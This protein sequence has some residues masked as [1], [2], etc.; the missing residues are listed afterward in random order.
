MGFFN[1]RC[2][3]CGKSVSKEASHCSHCG[4]PTANKWATCHQCGTSVG[5]ESKFCWKCGTEQKTDSRENFYGDRWRRSANDFAARVEMRV[6]GEVLHQG[7]LIDEGTVAVM[8]Q[9]GKPQGI[10]EPGYHSSEGFFSKLMGVNKNASAHAILLDME[11]AEVDFML[12]DVRLQ[13]LVPVDSRVRLLFKVSDAE[14]F[15][16]TVMGGDDSFTTQDLSARFQADVKS[17]AEHALK[18]QA[19]DKIVFAVSEREILEAGMQEKL[20]PALEAHGLSLAG[21][22]LAQFG[23][24]AYDQLKEKF[25]ELERLSRE[26]EAAR[27]LRD[28]VRAEKVA[29]YHDEEELK[30][31]Y[32][33][34]QTDYKLKS[35][36]REQEEARFIQAAEQQTEVEGV[37]LAYETRRAEILNRLDEQKLRH[38]S[39]L[40]D[41]QAELEQ[42][43]ARFEEDMRQQKERFKTGQEQ[44]K[45]QAKTDLEVAKQGIEAMKAVKAAKLEAKAAENEIEIEAEAKRLELRGNAS[46]QSLL[47]TLSGEQAD[48]VLKLAELEMRKGLSPEQALAMI[49]EKSPEIAPAV[50]DAIQARE[51]GAAKVEEPAADDDDEDVMEEER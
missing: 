31:A 5:A 37:R 26:A 4:C 15:V 44:Q 29:A 8:F 18:D 47:A 7:L 34:V 23:G 25:S 11:A 3:N 43:R 10:L 19:L 32:A 46:L 16:T 24:P 40:A 33:K 2:P 48:R 20:G 45:E 14:K 21:V 49:A 1:N 13:G 39:E 12:E 50:A 42:N 22:R 36:D 17:A 9:D 6:P 28:A 27:E 30:D 41:V 51:R 35:V 38:Q